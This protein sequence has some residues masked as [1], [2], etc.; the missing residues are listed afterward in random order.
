MSSSPSKSTIARSGL[1]VAS[2]RRS[3]T[4][5]LA[6]HLP[7]WGLRKATVNA[8]WR[9]SMP[10][11]RLSIGMTGS[12]RLDWALTQNNLGK[13]LESLGESET[14]TGLLHQAVEAYRAALEERV[15]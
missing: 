5:V 9:P 3:I 6:T 11:E 13:A 12:T 8:S 14:G 1:P 10:I 15:H 2:K 4:I 7:F